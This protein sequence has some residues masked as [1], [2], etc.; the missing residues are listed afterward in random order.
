V[1]IAASIGVGVGVQAVPD[2]LRP[3]P[4][5]A[6]TIFRSAITAGG[7]VAILLNAVLPP[8]AAERRPDPVE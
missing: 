7:L 4:A 5:T 8:H 3:L 1:I 6:Q 2:V